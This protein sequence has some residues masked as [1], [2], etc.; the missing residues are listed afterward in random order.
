MTKGPLTHHLMKARALTE[1][2]RDLEQVRYFIDC[3]MWIV[4]RVHRER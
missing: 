2:R 1:G 4:R 3:A